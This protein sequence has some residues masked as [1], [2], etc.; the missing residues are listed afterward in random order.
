M[1]KRKTH[2]EYVAELAIKNPK[3]EVVGQYVDSHTPILHRCLIDGHEWLARPNNLLRGQGCPKCHH[4]KVGDILRKTHDEYV[5]ELLIVNPYIEVIGK[6]VGATTQI[7]HRCII[8]DVVWNVSPDSALQGGGCNKCH[9]EK[10]GDRLRMNHEE[11]VRLVAIKNA[12]IEVVERY[13]N[14]KTP[15]LHRCKIHNITWKTQPCHVLEGHGC[16][17][18]SESYGEK[19]IR[20]W[21]DCHNIE[22]IPQKTFDNC[23][24]QR[25]LPFDSYIPAYNL[26]IE[27]D[28]EQH[29]KSVDFFGGEEG[30][31]QRQY[32]DMIK[33][34]YCN[35]HNIH[36]LR[37]PYFKN[38]ENELN[39][40]YS[41]NIV[42]SMVI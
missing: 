36:L 39:S 2:E 41:F 34:Q 33:T 28:G 8:H 3:I 18:C 29:F 13:I 27:Y 7:L 38:I 16:P 6:Y 30:L 12:N 23:K 37:I 1:S 31:K 24:N 15:I 4:K 40:F 9:Y 26:C 19:Q 20:Q 25:V 5:K 35:A 42:T 17:Q 21:L 32:N 10:I 14:A 22:Y 11:Y